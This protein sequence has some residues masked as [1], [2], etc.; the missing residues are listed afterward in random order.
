MNPF[1]SLSICFVLITVCWILVLLPAVSEHRARF[2]FGIIGLA[3]V[4]LGLRVLSET[5]MLT[6]PMMAPYRGLVDLVV[7]VLY[8]ACLLFLRSE[9]VSHRIT[10]LRLRLSQA[11][12]PSVP[13]LDE[14]TVSGILAGM[15]G[16]EA[17]ET[18]G[19]ASSGHEEV[20]LG[21]LIEGSPVA[22]VGLDGDGNVCLSNTA[23]VKLFQCRPGELVSKPVSRLAIP[24]N[25]G[26]KAGDPVGKRKRKR[27]A[28]KVKS[29]GDVEPQQA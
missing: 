2:L 25:C 10:R 22:I 23:A 24:T 12:E 18:G 8:F 16:D 15:N 27:T 17:G 28:S 26:C 1:A 20:M 11:M 21:K 4:F 19:N 9:T 13:R 6:I 14:A 29:P 7:A 5:G 3:S